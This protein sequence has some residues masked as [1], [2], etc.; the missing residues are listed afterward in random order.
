MILLKK[1]APFIAASTGSACG[2]SKPSRVLKAIGL[3]DTEIN[4]SL[5][6]SLSHYQN[7]D[8][9]KVIELL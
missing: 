9:L 2:V 8:D 1:M 7:I 4:S 3:S 5:R 6:L